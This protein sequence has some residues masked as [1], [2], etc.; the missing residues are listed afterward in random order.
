MPYV[1]NE[2]ANLYWDQL[3]SGPPILLIQGL[4]FTH[5]MWFRMLPVLQK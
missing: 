3:G 5:E 1:L 4:G 2:G